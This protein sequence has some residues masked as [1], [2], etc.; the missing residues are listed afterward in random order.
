MNGR[1]D[2]AN[3]AQRR[4]EKERKAA[5]SRL[6]ER[7]QSALLRT[8]EGQP[9]KCL[10]NV[11]TV[12]AWH[13][14]WAGVIAFDAFAESVVTLRRPPL[15]AQ[16]EFQFDAGEWTDELSVVTASWFGSEIGFEPG[17]DMVDRVVATHARK[18]VVHP[19]KDWL[20]SLQWDGTAR[21]DDLLPRYFGTPDTV[22]SRAVGSKWAISAVARVLQPGCQ[23]DAM[24]VLEGKQGAGKSTG[25]EALCGASWFADSGIDPGNK[26]SY[27]NLRSKWIYE[28]GELSSI[29]GREIEKVKAFVSARSDT[30][31]PSYGRRALSFPRQNV[32]VGTTNDSHY[33]SD[34]TGNRRFWPVRCERDIDVSLI[35]ADR[36]QLWAEAVARY[37][38]HEAWHVDTA[39]L[40]ALCVEEQSAHEQLDDWEPIVRQ[41]LTNPTVPV[42]GDREERELLNVGTGIGTAHV[43]LGALNLR[44]SD[45]NQ[46]ATTRAGYVLR[47]LGFEPRQ[48]RT[49][50]K[51]GHRQRLYFAS[52]DTTCDTQTVQN[53]PS[54]QVTPVTPIYPGNR[55]QNTQ[56]PYGGNP[57][58]TVVTCDTEFDAEE[59]EAIRNE[60]PAG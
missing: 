5:E 2:G 7:L 34:R 32:F 33:L 13:E 8:K 26:D 14:S 37:K 23:A 48:L 27:Q 38:A 45:V 46:T 35:R 12:L 18:K 44:P 58:G 15:R 56:N 10:A 43:L 16:D 53:T 28:F 6:T 30:Y 57:G 36:E 60:G 49:P 31:R 39:E 17:V 29:K 47:S 54:S 25:I 55:E 20:E 3:F 24:L 59:R 41:W 50:G 11:L 42:L 21:L 40:R 22:Y 1:L 19:V 52:R 4:T 9:K 51:S